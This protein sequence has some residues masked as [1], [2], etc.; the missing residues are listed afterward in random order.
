MDLVG[1]KKRGGEG[2]GIE[3][4]RKEREER[5]TN[6]ERDIK[7]LYTKKERVKKDI[8]ETTTKNTHMEYMYLFLQYTYL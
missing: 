3:G 8:K 1:G 4:K 5:Q 2:K 7:L 6:G